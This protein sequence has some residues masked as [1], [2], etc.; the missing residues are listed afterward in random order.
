MR[1][2]YTPNT[3]RSGLLACAHSDPTSAA[4]SVAQNRAGK[5]D[6]LR[7]DGMLDAARN[8]ADSLV[9]D[10]CEHVANG[11]CNS[12]GVIFA[13]ELANIAICARDRCYPD[14]DPLA[15]DVCPGCGATDCTP[16]TCPAYVEATP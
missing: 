3:V 8:N 13:Q 6:R 16:V 10:V 11:G 4:L 7:Q 1:R 9:H 15:V 14:D 2:P 12:A 5:I